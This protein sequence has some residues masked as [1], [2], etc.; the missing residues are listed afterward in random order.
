MGIRNHKDLTIWIRACELTLEIYE[1]TDTYPKM[2]LYVLVSQMR[3]AAISVPSNIAEGAARQSTKEF[4]RYLQIASGS[5]SELE[6]QLIL[7]I[8]L[9]LLNKKQKEYVD[10]SEKILT[11]RKQIYATIRSLRLRL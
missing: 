1:I 3:R 2:K 7:S 5:L 4:I 9:G 6:T 8:N 11:L 10:A